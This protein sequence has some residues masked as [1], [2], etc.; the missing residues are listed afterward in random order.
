MHIAAMCNN[1]DD[2]NKDEYNKDDQNETDN[3]TY[4]HNQ[5]KLWKNPSLEHQS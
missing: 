5:S 2:H 1:K 4:S 3:L